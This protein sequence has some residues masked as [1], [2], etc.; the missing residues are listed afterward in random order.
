[1]LTRRH[2]AKI[3]VLVSIASACA[4][5][6][7]AQAPGQDGRQ[8]TNSPPLFNLDFPGGELNAFLEAVRTAHPGANVVSPQD[9]ASFPIPP[10]Q[11]RNITLEAAMRLLEGTAELPDGREARIGIAP[12]GVSGSWDPAVRVKYEVSTRSRWGELQ[13]SVW[14]LT[15]TISSN[16]SAD[17]VLGAV[18]VALATF[19]V[20]STIRFHE[21]T[22]LLIVRGT[23][24]QLQL[25]DKTLGQ[26]R[27]DTSRS[28]SEAD[29]FG[30][31]IRSLESQLIETQA[32]LRVAQKRE[33][34]ARKAFVAKSDDAQAQLKSGAMSPVA[35]ESW[36]GEAELELVEA[37]AEHQIA[38]EE[39]RQLSMRL[40]DA[41]DYL[42]KITG[43][44]K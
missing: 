18:Q 25:V 19:P 33:E 20:E 35:A 1:M 36:I 9:A 38:Q 27:G 39:L 17:D 34:V 14:S 42:S 5:P 32:R 28:S 30:A 2:L 26:L 12:I 44:G 43:G 37:E 7:F 15:E 41:R 31:L 24:A 22:S 6:L 21:P 29:S 8:P 13:S 4:A 23:E 3:F 10:M 16:R 11:L 40:K